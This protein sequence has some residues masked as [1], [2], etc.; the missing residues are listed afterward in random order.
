MSTERISRAFLEERYLEH[1]G[2]S[3]VGRQMFME[4]LEDVLRSKEPRVYTDASSGLSEAEQEVLT[5]GG[6][7]LNRTAGRDLVAETAVAF[8]NLV[9][10]SLTSGEVAGR[11]GLTPTRIRQMIRDREI[12]SFLLN[13][14]RLV[15]QF[16][17]Q[18]N[19]L[20]N[21]IR[22]VNRSLH[23][24]LH[25]VGVDEWFRR[26]NPELFI[27]TKSIAHRSPLNWLIEGRDPAKVAFLAE[28]L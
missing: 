16:Q 15:P 24:G 20:V 3:G 8:A 10:S 6:L 5:S 4:A 2:I 23:E 19:S 7:R 18:G 27:D 1:R 28:S 22:S 9:A 11:M 25:P 21:N 17:F 13:G 12:Y 14:K 26:D